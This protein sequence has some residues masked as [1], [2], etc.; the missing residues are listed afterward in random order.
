MVNLSK[1]SSKGKFMFLAYD[2]GLEHGPKDFTIAT[3]DPNYILDIA[4]KG[5]FNAVILQKGI[6]EKYYSPY[7]N[8]IPLIVKLNGKTNLV[9]G[10]PYSAPLCT[11]D[12]AIKLGAKGVGYTVYVGSKFE[13]IMF[14]EF[15]RVTS[16]A[17]SK[18][19]PVIAWMYPR[20]SAV[21]GKENSKEILAY[22]ARVGLEL[23]G[24]ILKMHYAGNVNDMRWVVK[25]AGRAKV[26][27][28]GGL[29]EKE[30]DFLKD[31]KDAIKA[32]CAGIAV[33][34]NVWQAKDPLHISGEIRKIILE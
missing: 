23:G 2:H 31:L 17:H 33:G 16:E 10:E 19:I 6:A 34:R 30:E 32:G 21:S 13:S 27:I 8:K 14:K 20:G 5:K 3:M 22:S 29:K 7:K 15:S 11:V 18:N 25:N 12:E 1:I 4:V 24:D 9:D 28:S 26:V